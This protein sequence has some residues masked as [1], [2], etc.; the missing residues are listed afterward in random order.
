MS[1]HKQ[2]SISKGHNVAASTEGLLSA[3]P[4]SL[5]K[6]YQSQ[7]ELQDI[8]AS[9]IKKAWFTMSHLMLSPGSHVVDM[10]CDTGE[11]TY[12]MAVMHPD[13]LFTG[14]DQSPKNIKAANKKFQ[15]D[16]ISFVAGDIRS[17]AGLEEE[18]YD[19]IVNSFILFEIFSQS[20]YNEQAVINT[21][22]NQFKLLKQNGLMFI[23][24][25]S[26]PSPGSYVML[27]MPD[28]PSKNKELKGMSEADLLVWYS[29]NARPG[30]LPGCNGFFLEELPPRFPKMR[31]FRLP[32][33]WAYEFMIRKDNRS[34]WAKDLQ[35]EYTFFT[36]REYRKN[37]RSLGA[38][39]LYTAP[40][41]DEK[42]IRE[43]FD[44][45]FRLYDDNG[46]L[47]GSPPTSFIAVAQK[48]REKDSL[49]LH[50]RRPSTKTEGKIRISSMRDESTGKMVDLVCRDVDITEV[51]PYRVTADGTLNVYIHEGLPR[52]LSNAIPRVGKEI[53]GKRWSGH[54]TEAISVPTEIIHDVTTGNE[55]VTAKFT[56]DYLGLKPAIGSELEQGPSYYPAPDTIDEL[57]KT[58]YIE[59]KVPEG[60]IKPR[61]MIEDVA[62]FTTTGNIIEIKAQS[63]LNAISIGFIPNS[64]LELQIQFL[65]QRLGIRSESWAESPM[66]LQ[67]SRDPENKFDSETFSRSLAEEDKRFRNIRG[68]SGQLRSV[69]SIFVDEGWVDGGIMGLAAQDQ[70]FIIS[71]EDT[72]N[73]AT[74]I[75]LTKDAE[76]KIH[77]GFVTEYMPVPQ[78]HKGNGMTITSPCFALPKEIESVEEARKYVAEMYKVP[79]ECVWRLGESYYS[80]ISVTP[81][82]IFPFAIS[83]HGSSY[84]PTGGPFEYAPVEYIW[85]MMWLNWEWPHTL[86]F[87]SRIRNVYDFYLNDSDLQLDFVKGREM[88]APDHSP[89]IHKTVDITGRAAYS[90][91]S[92]DSGNKEASK[93]HAKTEASP[94]SFRPNLTNLQ[95]KDTEGEKAWQPSSADAMDSKNA[96]ERYSPEHSRVRS[97]KAAN[98][99]SHKHK[100]EDG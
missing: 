63:I 44:G 28:S 35:K 12:T 48:R 89:R 64:R 69:K 90:A 68:T 34:N 14:V 4:Q 54:M 36:Q 80:H 47:M 96:Q 73:K 88:N 84:N 49:C 75:P 97:K 30:G 53:D 72:M 32:Y 85:N 93:A 55:A 24:D 79:L 76:G 86:Y 6:Y 18:K 1:E 81:E 29:E 15:R 78:R 41:W 98:D 45:R 23:R 58:R 27:E 5:F 95:I 20:K 25:H 65:M 87:M 70:E 66:I 21:L 33:K 67:E 82:R 11:M 94:S 40:H 92:N 52:S 99:K 42:M 10:G 43:K 56:R 77:A 13:L 31:L 57:V 7:P 9:V 71:S 46:R 19:A 91:P 51:I 2:A 38:R 59:V 17:N 37:L 61:K 50:E 83:T 22:N 100:R 74:V 3:P 62:G 26:M 60:A 8:P 39:V 16:N